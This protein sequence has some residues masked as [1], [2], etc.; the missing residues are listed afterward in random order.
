MIRTG[1]ACVQSGNAPLVLDPG[2]SMKIAVIGSGISGL[3][4]AWL[5]SRAH[6]VTLFERDGRPGGHSNTIDARVGGRSVEV[7]TGFIVYNTRSYP[8]L[9]ALFRHLGVETAASNMSFAVSLGGG[10]Y[11]YSGSGL[12]GLFGQPGNL[13]DAGHWTMLR[14]IRRF[15]CEA[16]RIAGLEDPESRSLGEFLR[17][18]NYSQAFIERHILPMAAAIWSCP[19]R[20]MLDFPAVSFA[21]FF[22]NHG[23]LQV[24]DRPQWRTVA[25]GSRKYVEAL[26]ADFRGQIA[27]GRPVA[28]IERDA[29]AAT[30]VDTAGARER[31]DACVV[32][33][34]ADE[35]LAMLAEPDALERELL[36]AF[37]YQT[38]RAVLH[39]DERHMPLR[40]RVWSSWNVVGD[41][42]PEAPVSVTYWMNKLQPLPI[43]RQIFVTLNPRMEI[44][45]GAE[46]A[47]FD[48]DHPVFDGRALAAQGRLWSLQG[49]NR[50]WYCGSYFGYGFH[51][52]GLQAGLAA[53]EDLGGVR[54]P[55]KVENE[56]GRIPLH[57]AMLAPMREAAE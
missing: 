15:F 9:I 12:G 35:A 3:S 52:D 29:A 1:R 57:S 56:S 2:F 42:H 24:K 49:R 50:T 45:P 44:T 40:R 38:N 32:A 34:H 6:E 41:A 5:L 22:A 20:I 39:T 7:D 25:G 18:G 55:W 48:Y 11:E 30:V 47:A 53:A 19:P 37:A 10:R 23:L 17:R 26:L 21:R 43:D 33:A 46:I 14:D 4:A 54:R 31:Y 13:L 8:N 36:S 16:A 51:E 28:R 27:L